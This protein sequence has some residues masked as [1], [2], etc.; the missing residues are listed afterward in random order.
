MSAKT[1]KCYD[2][3]GSE[4][5]DGDQVDVQRAGVHHVY[6]KPDGHLYF[7]P[8]GQEEQVSSYFS[9]DLVKV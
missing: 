3:W 1:I 8:Y 9:N 7:T 6:K 2:Q 4:L 5:K